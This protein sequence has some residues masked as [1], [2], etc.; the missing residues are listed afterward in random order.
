MSRG[1][2]ADLTYIN[3]VEQQIRRTPTH[4][5]RHLQLD[6]HAISS[7]SRCKRQALAR[8][9]WTLMARDKNPPRN[10]AACGG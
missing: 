9:R 2:K 3:F 10:Q 7:Q 1:V 5:F 8:A 4:R 6:H